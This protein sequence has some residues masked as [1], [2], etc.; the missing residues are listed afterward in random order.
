MSN[1]PPSRTSPGPD[2]GLFGPGSAA[3]RLH[4]EP[5]LLVG[6][7]SA[8]MWQALH[9]LAIAAVADHSDYRKDVWGRYDRT[10]N[11]VMTTIFG[12]TKQAQALGARVRAVHVPIHGVDK[13][14]GLPYAADDPTLLLWIHGTLVASFLAAYR[15]FVRPLSAGE[16]DGYV[17]EMVRQAE[18]VG[19]KA[20]AV[21]ASEAANLAFL[22][23]SAHLLQVTRPAREAVDTVLHPPLPVFLR[24][25]WAVAGQAAISILPEGALQLYGM[26]RP[27]LA[28]A[29]VRPL[30]GGGAWFAG[31][32]LKPPPVLRQARARAAAGGRR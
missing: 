8:L 14:T 29:A 30:V 18:L 10:S 25:V 17:A 32:F 3:W 22:D 16:A 23:S 1:P 21:P 2:L 15:R 7:L 9:P 20:G 26:R 5:A 28:A 4:S 31:R 6:G 11:Y 13:V 19:L 24:P 12:T 27:R